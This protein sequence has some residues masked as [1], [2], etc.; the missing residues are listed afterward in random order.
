MEYLSA[1]RC[2][3]MRA[4]EQGKDRFS[5][6]GIRMTK[7]D[8]SLKEK[9][10]GLPSLQGPFRDIDMAALPDTPHEAFLAWL[11]EA[12]AHGITE[13]HAMTLST[14]DE[15]GWPDARVLILKNIDERGWHFA[16][17]ADCPK[18]QQ[19]AG[20]CQV[21]LTF[22]WPQLGRQ[23]RLRG[24]AVEL[25]DA[26][27]AEDFLRRPIGSKVVAIASK[28]SQVLPTHDA[29]MC[30]LAEAS[31]FLESNPGHVESRWRVFAV[32]PDIVEFWQGA[33]DRLHKRLQ[34]V[35]TSECGRW[36]KHHLWL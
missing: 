19:I 14:V 22:Y 15:N 10:R 25:Q 8:R 35:F 24:K 12:I 1:Q 36:Q 27:C 23:I 34:Y 32:S 30:R 6:R 31:A 28:Q 26:E 13:P 11:D 17:K 29:L 3:T 21:A 4:W 18:G 16:T 33:T 2:L 9:L 7:S 5:Q 20:N